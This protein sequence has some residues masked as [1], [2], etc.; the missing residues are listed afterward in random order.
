MAAATSKPSEL[1]RLIDEM[2]GFFDVRIGADWSGEL[3]KSVS[4]VT[5]T[6][7]HPEA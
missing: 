5:V 3:L 6:S 1:S 7:D 2:D 4:D